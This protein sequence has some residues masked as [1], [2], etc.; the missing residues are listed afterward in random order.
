MPSIYNKIHRLKKLWTWEQFVGQYDIGP[1]IKTL[2][3]NYKYPHHK[4]ARHTSEVINL[5]HEQHFP[6]PFPA[7]IDG[8]MDVYDTLHHL[9]ESYR[10]ASEIEKLENFIQYELKIVG[11]GDALRLARLN[12]LLGDIYFDQISLKRADKIESDKEKVKAIHTYHQ[13]LAYIEN[14]TN[15]DETVKYKVRQNIL[16]CY[17]NSAKYKGVELKDDRDTM[18]YLIESCFLEKTKEF[19]QIEPF[20]WN[21]ARNGLRFSSLLEDENNTLFFFEKLLM[22]SPLFIDLD[23]TPYQAPAI[24]KSVDFQWAIQ[25]VLTQELLKNLE[26]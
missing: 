26:K 23:Y 8:L 19:L 25:H 6:S 24:S 17:L 7:A 22:C 4:P 21:I 2:K 16:A 12:W 13:A 5:L 9:D 3:A 18:S 1:D 14:Q 11:S 10:L 20:N 15:L